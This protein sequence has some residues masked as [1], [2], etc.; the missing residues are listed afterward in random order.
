LVQELSGRHEALSH[1]L[2]F[3]DIVDQLLSL[4]LRE[5]REVWD[6]IRLF[7]ELLTGHLIQILGHRHRSRGELALQRVALTLELSLTLVWHRGH[8]AGSHL[9]SRILPADRVEVL[10]LLG[11]LVVCALLAISLLVLVCGRINVKI[12]S[13]YPF[14]RARGRGCNAYGSSVGLRRRRMRSFGPEG[15]GYR[16]P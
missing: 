15:A 11:C 10:L 9:G 2:A 7:L 1:V 4:Y 13:S 16:T 8:H 6:G 5:L 12:I 14:E 3:Q